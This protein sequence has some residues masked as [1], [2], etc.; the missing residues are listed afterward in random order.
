MC[1]HK[2]HWGPVHI[3]HIPGV[4]ALL[5]LRHDPVYPRHTP[6]TFLFTGFA[7]TLCMFSTS[8]VSHCTPRALS[9]TANAVRQWSTIVGIFNV[10]YRAALG[11]FPL[12]CK[13]ITLRRSLQ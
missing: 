1:H 4:T 3:H 13:G 12:N 11:H 5:R 7:T 8:L 10:L 6:V 2:L 9:R